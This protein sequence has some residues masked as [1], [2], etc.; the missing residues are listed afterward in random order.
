M[1]ITKLLSFL[2]VFMT[3]GFTAQEKINLVI[4]SEDGDAFY[5][6]VNGIRQNDKYETNVKVTGVSPNVSLRIEFENKAYPSLKKAGYFEAGMEHTIRIKRDTKQVVKLTYFG[7]TTLAESQ[8]NGATT[9]AYHPAE[10][11]INTTTQP[12][13]PAPQNTNMEQNTNMSVGGTTVTTTTTTGG[14]N[15]ENVNMNIN[16]GGVGINMNV[17]G[18][19]PVTR[20]QTVTSTTVTTRSSTNISEGNGSNNNTNTNGGVSVS[21]AGAGASKAGCVTAMSAANFAKMKQNVE[22]KPFSDTKMSTAKIATKNACLSVDQVKEICNLFSM[23]DDKLAYAKYAY[24]Y[25]VDKST[26]YEIGDIFSFSSTTDEFN[27]FLEK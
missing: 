20:Q 5:A 1:K 18:N 24:D 2:L 17:G 27:K 22:S 3:V 9:I 16:V 14:Q 15:N 19:M 13:T 7:Q 23:D 21:N 12:N 6:Y 8:N 26:Y 10:N 11:P 25:C 4:F